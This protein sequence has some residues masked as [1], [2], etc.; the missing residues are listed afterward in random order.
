[1]PSEY[2]RRRLAAGGPRLGTPG[3]GPKSIGLEFGYAGI[4]VD[5]RRAGRADGDRGGAR[6]G[7]GEL[8]ALEHPGA[9]AG[10]PVL[11]QPPGLQ[12]VLMILLELRSL[13]TWRRP[14]MFGGIG[15]HVV[16]QGE[17]FGPL[18]LMLLGPLGL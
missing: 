14:P 4:P 9:P 10:D 3:Q 1:M 13:P 6:M 2:I 17:A 8:C 15:S 16:V 7:V 11:E 5:R 12:G 18:S